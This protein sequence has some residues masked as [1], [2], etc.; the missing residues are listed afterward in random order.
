MTTASYPFQTVSDTALGVAFCRALESDRPDA[1]FSDP[2]ARRLAGD[3]GEA[4]IA[5]AGKRRGMGW[6]VVTRTWMIDQWITAAVAGGVDVVLNLAAGLDTRPYRLDLPPS[7][8]WVEVDLPGVIHYKRSQLSDL[9]PHCQLERL[10]LDLGDRPSRQAL[11]ADW[12][13]SRPL[14]LTE[15]LL[16]YWHQAAVEDLAEDLLALNPTQWITDSIC[17]LTLKIMQR[18]WRRVLSPEAMFQF[19]PPSGF[20]QS[21]GWQVLETRSLWQ[22]AHDLDREVSIGQLLRHIPSF[23][24][25]ALLRLQP[26]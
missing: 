2:Y 22:Q 5:A 6:S 19:A 14:I 4:M 7:V 11:L 3:R 8:I 12:Q 9:A 24:G 23:R 20:F 26:D 13:G 21:R 18:R 10:A 25:D 15:G 1:I 17:P 16:L